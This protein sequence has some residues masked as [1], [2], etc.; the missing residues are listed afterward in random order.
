MKQ[1]EIILVSKLIKMRRIA[2]RLGGNRKIGVIGVVD[3]LDRHIKANGYNKPNES[4]MFLLRHFEKIEYIIPAGKQKL[5]NE[6]N[7]LV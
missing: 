3:F 5:Y 2:E 6:L 4:R 7:D 1:P